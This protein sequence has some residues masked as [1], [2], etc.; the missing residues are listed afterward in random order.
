[1]LLL[2]GSSAH[3][4][5]AVG[6][7]AAIQWVPVRE[8]REDLFSSRPREPIAEQRDHYAQQERE[9]YR[10]RVYARLELEKLVDKT[11]DKTL[12]NFVTKR[13]TKL[14]TKL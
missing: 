8:L 1:M 5:A 14:V 3:V 13:L 2:G 10:A 9:S 11:V 6:L 7:A 4:K 12:K